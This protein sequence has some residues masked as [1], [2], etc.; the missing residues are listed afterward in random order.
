MSASSSIFIYGEQE[1]AAEL[2]LPAS[3]L[4]KNR[5]KK[6]ASGTDWDLNKGRVA[7][8]APGAIRAVQLLTEQKMFGAPTTDLAEVEALIE[9]SRL[10]VN[11]ELPEVDGT[12]ARFW[13]NPHLVDFELP[14][15][16][17]ARV[18]VQSTKNLRAGMVL[19][20][21]K[22]PEGEYELAGRLP[23]SVREGRRHARGA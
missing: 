1:L 20:L 5:T 19:K 22:S 13:S 14:D 8:S 11:G 21:V 2:G 7:Y 3:I 16:T 10:L 23:R 4:Q 15:K 17:I 12:I 18:R 6:L 9:K